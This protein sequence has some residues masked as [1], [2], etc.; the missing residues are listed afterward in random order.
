MKRL[1]AARSLKI[2]RPSEPFNKLYNLLETSITAGFPVL[3]ENV[4][5]SIDQLFEPILQNK[6]VKQGSSYK[7]K[8]CVF[9]ILS[10]LN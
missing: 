10:K 6:L 9:Y 5:E 2:I 1:E 8:V 3:L 4:S 7:L